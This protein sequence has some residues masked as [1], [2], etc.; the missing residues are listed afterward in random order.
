MI[1]AAIEITVNIFQS[2]LV[3]FFT[4][5][6]LH[7]KKQSWLADCSC[8][9][10]CT[11]FYS[12]Y[13]IV[14]VP[15]NDNWIFIIPFIYSL[16]VS[17]DQWPL[18]LFWMIVLALLFST[19]IGA[20]FPIFAGVFDVHPSLLMMP[21]GL[22]LAFLLFANS[23]LF[24]VIY[25]ASK[26][27][28]DSIYMSWPSML[29]ILLISVA[30]LIV[31]ECLYGLQSCSDTPSFLYCVAYAGLLS[32]TVL[33]IL[34]FRFLSESSSREHE[35][36]SEI[37]T[38]TLTQKHHSEF[39]TV[40]SDFV[41]RE[42]DFK[43][44]LETIERLIKQ[45]NCEAASS[46]LASYQSTLP[47]PRLF[48]TGCIEV[49]A[50]L[51]AKYYTMK[52][53][54]ISFH[55]TPHPLHSLPISSADFCSIVGNLLDNA[56]EG[57]LRIPSPSSSLTISLTFA[58]T[59]DVFHIMC[60]NAC[61]PNTIQKRRNQWISSKIAECIPGSHGIGIS[62]IERIVNKAEGYCRF[63]VQDNIFSAELIIPYP[64]HNQ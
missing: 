62:S 29:T 57:L 15:L 24:C 36:K 26:L 51:T 40:Y 1:W 38:Y 11:L 43:H 17:S 61:N 49:D 28:C 3:L 7:I 56:I 21:G 45:S 47:D 54:Q 4:K 8:I 34:L 22:R 41:S 16:R 48:I 5:R 14:D 9:A 63:Y 25:L 18:S 58:R 19:T 13:L 27:Q 37:S 32:C 44:H 2:F 6:H 42:H 30:I 50:L 64:A 53:H 55:F 23:I 10:C 12:L 59:Y 31:E 46:Y 52:A 35:Y 60:E 33:S 39:T 20:A